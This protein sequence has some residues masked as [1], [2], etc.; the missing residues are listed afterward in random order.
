MWLLVHGCR[1]T[2]YLGNG[3]TGEF[4]FSEGFHHVWPQPQVG[5]APSCFPLQCRML[6]TAGGGE[7]MCDNLGNKTFTI[8]ADSN[9][10]HSVSLSVRVR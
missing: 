7:E 1:A 10:A 4:D 6:Q 3:G 2:H 5:E 9:Y 8:K